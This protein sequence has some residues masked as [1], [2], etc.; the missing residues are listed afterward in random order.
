[1]PDALDPRSPSALL[2]DGPARD[3][4]FTVAERWVECATFPD[5]DPMREI[6]FFHRQMNEE[7]DSLECCARHLSDFRTEEWDIRMGLARQCSDEARHAVMF[8]RIFESR[9][10]VVG[11]Y[12]VLNFQY[13]IITKIPSLVGRMAVQNRSFE[14]GGLDAIKY[15]IEVAE[16]QGDTELAELYRAQ[17]ADEIG[18]VRFANDC[19]R[20]ATAKNLRAVLD[21]GT[22][23]TGASKAF[24]EVMGS[25]GT[26]GV[27]Y[28]A[29]AEGRLEAGFTESEIRMVVDL[30]NQTGR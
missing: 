14:A 7:V 1:M 15:G 27:N 13:R 12:P 18:H 17:Y 4:R 25:E 20:K 30:Q 6:E 8:R 26:A 3:P 16:Q 21:I 24:A 28:P 29:D 22:A 23:L 11:Q 5:G 19:I 10:G 9:G 2:A